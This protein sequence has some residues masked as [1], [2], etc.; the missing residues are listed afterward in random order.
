MRII[1]KRALREFWT[2]HPKAKAP[3]EAW[4]AET[5]K[6]DW[7]TS[8][9]IKARYSSASFLAD[10]RIVFNIK[11]NDYRLIVRINYHYK[12][13]YVRFVGTHAEYD[14]INAET[15]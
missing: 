15:V 4:Y 9:N 2:S 5:E 14:K 6:A 10:N 13:V 8:Q 7:N 11:G 3:L 12:V 1:A